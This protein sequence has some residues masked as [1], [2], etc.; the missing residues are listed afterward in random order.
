MFHLCCYCARFFGT[1]DLYFFLRRYLIAA[2]CNIVII[3]C[4]VVDGN[5]ITKERYDF[6]TLYIWPNEIVALRGGCLSCIMRR[7]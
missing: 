6:N 2:T 5:I 7:I 3:H 4:T 1:T